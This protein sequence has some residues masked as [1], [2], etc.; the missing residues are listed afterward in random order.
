[1]NSMSKPDVVWN[2]TWNLL[3]D[4]IVYQKKKEL[5]VQG[6]NCT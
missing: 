2:A 4:G 1:M 6:K 3:A 5:N